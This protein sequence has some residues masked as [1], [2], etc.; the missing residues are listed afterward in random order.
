MANPKDG[1]PIPRAHGSRMIERLT[2]ALEDVECRS[3]AEL[4]GLLTDGYAHAHEMETRLLRLRSAHPVVREEES[5]RLE[6]DR[7]RARLA[8]LR[9]AVDDLRPGV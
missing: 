4:L 8:E 6:L 5:L 3:Q 1:D 7:L 2:R 9:L